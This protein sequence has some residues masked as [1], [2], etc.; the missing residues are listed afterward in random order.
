MHTQKRVLVVVPA[1]GGSKGVP[2]K[3]LRK[4]AGKS[5]VEHVGHLVRQ[6]DWV[7]RAVVSTDHSEIAKTAEKAGLAAPFW[8][9]AELSGDRIGDIPVLQHALQ[10]TESADGCKYDIVVML[11]P[12]APL[13]RAEHVIATVE[14]LIQENYD[15]VWTVSLTDLK[16]HPLKQLALNNGEILGLLDQRGA[17]IIARQQLDTVYHRNGAAYALTRE[18]LL[19]QS[20]LLGARSGAV[21]T[22]GPMLS[23]DSEDDLAQAESLLLTGSSQ[24]SPPLMVRQEGAATPF[25]T[26]VVDIDGVIASLVSNNDY[27]LSQPILENICIINRLYEA[28]HKIILFTARGSATGID[29]ENL[30]RSQM[31]E[32]NVHYHMLQFGKPAADYYI[33]DRLITLEEALH[34][35]G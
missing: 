29:W 32:W 1:R 22:E 26:F 3:N 8:R 2:L 19:N 17:E 28:G 9:P 13:R 14:K 7:D 10:A 23:I 15:A 16:Y 5:L 21:I 11:Q 25:K 33:D 31:T 12:T 6:L 24:K 18:C 34:H 27:T 35:C 4:I 20:V 30:T